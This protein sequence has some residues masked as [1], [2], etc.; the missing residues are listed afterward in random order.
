MFPKRVLHV[1][2]AVRFGEMQLGPPA[3]LFCGTRGL[4]AGSRNAA[5]VIVG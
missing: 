1:P 3:G 5:V 2:G 4:L